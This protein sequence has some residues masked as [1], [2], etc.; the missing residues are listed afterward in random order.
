MQYINALE[1]RQ[2]ATLVGEGGGV[3]IEGGGVEKKRG[4]Y[5][6]NKMEVVQ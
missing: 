5:M 2:P 1:N 4:T 3:G 6:D